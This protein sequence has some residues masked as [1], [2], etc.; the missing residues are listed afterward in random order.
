M[1]E[2]QKER[3][4][5]QTNEDSSVWKKEEQRGGL[6]FNYYHRVKDKGQ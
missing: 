6:V 5:G 2:Q 3:R 4:E 1:I